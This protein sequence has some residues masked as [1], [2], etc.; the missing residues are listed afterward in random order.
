MRKVISLLLALVLV[1]GLVA[2]AL[3]ATV[4]M[5]TPAVT[6]LAK[7]E[8]ITIT[9]T[10]DEALENLIG[11]DYELY[12]DS[13]KFTPASQE[14][15]SVSVSNPLT[16]KNG[17]TYFSLSKTNFTGDGTFSIEAGTLATL[18][19]EALVDFTGEEASAFRLEKETLWD[20]SWS[21]ENIEDGEVATPE[22]LVPALTYT[23]TLP[24]NPVGYTIAAVEGSASPVTKGG[25]FSFTVTVDTENYEGEPAVTANGLTLAA[26]DGVYTISNITENQVVTVGGIK[27]QGLAADKVIYQNG[28]IGGSGWPVASP[29]YVNSLTLKGLS[30]TNVA[31]DDA[32]EICTVTLHKKTAQDA[33]FTLSGQVAVMGQPQMKGMF[34][35]KVNGAAV[36]VGNN[37]VF[38]Y[39]ASLEGGRGQLGVTASVQNT[40]KTKTINLVVDGTAEPVKTYDVTLTEGEG[41]TIT[42]SEGSASPVTGGG[43]FSFT[44]SVSDG[45]EGSPVVKVNGTELTAA[46]GVYT[47]E[48]ITE[49]KTVTVEGITAKPN[50]YAVTLTEGVGY[51]I[52]AAEGSASPVTEGGSFSFT[53]TVKNGYEGSPVVKVNGEGLTAVDGVYTIANITEAKTVTVE[54]I[55]IKANTYTVEASADVAAEKDG[56]VQVSILV[57]GNSDESI[58]QY[59]DYDVEIS[60]DTEGLTYV[61]AIAAHE[62]AKVIPAEGGSVRIV[63]HGAPWSYSDA[64]AV[65]TFTA[66][67]SG[68]YNVTIRSAKIDNSGHAITENAPFAAISD[69]MT[70][71]KVAYPVTL[72]EGFQGENSALPGESYTFTI[73]DG[74]DASG[75]TVTVG[76]EEIVPVINGNTVTVPNVNGDVV[77]K[78][79]Y[80]VVT[81][82]EENVSVSAGN[83]AVYGE[84]FTFITGANE[85]YTAQVAITINGK[86]YNGFTTDGKGG[87]T[88]P[89]KDILGKLEITVTALVDVAGQTKITFSGNVSASEVEGGLIQYAE[90]NKD[91]D[92]RLNKQEGY[93][94]VVTLEGSELKA[95]GEGNYTISG[96]LITGVPLTVYINKE[97]YVPA[98]LE[99]AVTNY[100]QLDETNMWL[101]TATQGDAVLAYEGITMFWSDKYEAYCWLVI[102]DAG[103]DAVKAA[104]E[105]VILPVADTVAKHIAYDYDVN[106]SG[107]VDVNDAQLTYDMYQAKK[108]AD[109]ELVSRDRF[110]EA[111]VNADMVV[112][113]EDA[114]AVVAE[115]LN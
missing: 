64:L 73:P 109:F 70:V 50:T 32:N 90:N 114:A 22:L 56:Q 20:D 111:D 91:F 58:T 13:T 86:A 54:G 31:W 59:N 98:A 15:G 23:V 67:A 104:A 76:G 10:L 115:I 60:Y 33:A 48:N 30:V 44:V 81:K 61:S 7:G 14:A 35:A 39:S 108:Y 74:M 103:E 106:Q 107:D 79:E 17:N 36:T 62:G 26:T 2:P 77:V 100:I 41:Y 8:Q 57:T 110:L 68:T 82:A 95:N 16:D 113:V 19:F 78:A 92:F 102:S 89:G 101:I 37:A 85:G 65:L 75:V 93:V 63:G 96:D 52:T 112:N 38:T 53:V 42:A 94:Y 105:A 66:K 49:A 4:D 24:E 40:A 18:T 69:N 12:Y 25:S 88:I 28:G 27:E 6:T 87:Y 9:V 99:V 45:Y 29:V 84:D 21:C 51:T 47:I 97:V 43:S 11:F 1:C 80:Q 83:T 3:A 55:A 72:P 5:S 46:N 34:S 71:V